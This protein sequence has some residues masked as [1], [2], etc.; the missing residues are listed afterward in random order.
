MVTLT[1]NEILDQLDK[2]GITTPSEIQ[3]YIREYH[4]YFLFIYKEF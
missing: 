4:N 3:A 1:K 2:L